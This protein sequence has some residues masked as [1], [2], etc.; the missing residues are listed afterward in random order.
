MD[1]QIDDGGMIQT[2][3]ERESERWKDEAMRHEGK[4]D[5]PSSGLLYYHFTA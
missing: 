2:E 1:G 5:M 3:R 4:C